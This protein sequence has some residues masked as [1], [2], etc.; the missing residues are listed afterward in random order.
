MPH[1]LPTART[2]NDA[3]TALTTTKDRASREREAVRSIAL[4]VAL[5]ASV[6]F[7]AAP[8]LAGASKKAHLSASQQL[9]KATEPETLAEREARLNK[10]PPYA[11]GVFNTSLTSL[12][13]HFRG[14]SFMTLYKEAVMVGPKGEFETT[15]EYTARSKKDVDTT[16]AIVLN[17]SDLTA[18]PIYDA[19][20][21]TMSPSVRLRSVFIG[22]GSRSEG[23]FHGY[24]QGYIVDFVPNGQRQYPASNAFGASTVVTSTTSDTRAILPMGPLSTGAT[25]EFKVPR[26]EAQQIKVRLKMLVI[27]SIASQQEPVIGVDQGWN[28]FYATTATITDPSETFTHYYLLRMNIADLWAFDSETGTVLARY[29]EPRLEIRTINPAARR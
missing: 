8:P 9:P 17:A 27:G 4:V 2:K 28:G 6:L 10:E 7:T 20:K 15:A 12:P 23:Q 24:G 14:N 29:S 22:L 21:E 18:P 5:A 16:Y 19:D 1:H 25:L 26:A 13:A 3:V 11:T